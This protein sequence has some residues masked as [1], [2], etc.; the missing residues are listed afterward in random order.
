M[1]RGRKAEPAAIKDLKGNPGKRPIARQESDIADL[2]GKPPAFMRRQ[3]ARRIYTDLH[4]ELTATNILR[5]TDVNAFTRYCEYMADWIELTGQLRKKGTRTVYE[6]DTRHGRMLRIHPYFTARGRLEDDIVKL[7]D[8]LGLTPRARQSI[9]QQFA[10][11]Q[12]ELPGFA[13]P[14]PRPAADDDQG[15]PVLGGLSGGQ[16]H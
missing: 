2:A 12:P 6:T 15:V 14:D 16:V 10:N 1:A 9:L 13:E 5:A 3:S 8:H 4:R 11:V 7:E